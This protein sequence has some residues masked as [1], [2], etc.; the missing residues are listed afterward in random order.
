MS[1][2][3]KLILL[4][5][6]ALLCSCARG[7]T[8]YVTPQYSNDFGVFLGLSTYQYEKL[9][10][11]KNVAIEI[12]EFEPEHLRVV[13]NYNIDIYAYLSVGSLEE[14]KD[15]YFDFKDYELMEYENWPGEY[16]MDVTYTP[17][18]DK[19]VSLA[20]EFKD[21][22]AKGL[23]LDNFDIYYQIE[24]GEWDPSFKEEIYQACKI[25]LSRLSD[26]GMSLVVNSGSTFLERLNEENDPL[27]SKIEWYAQETVFTS[28]INYSGDVF[29]RQTEEEK[30]Y[31]LS[32]IEFMK[33]TANI[34]LIEYATDTEIIEEIQA[35][36]NANGLYFYIANSTS[37]N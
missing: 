19:M 20:N 21:L 11:Y 26:T 32:V 16:W 6:S 25:I 23:F 24:S 1:F 12:E 3:K 18:Q 22:G 35:Y 8:N 30:E 28:I 10:T 37:L 5:S 33:K 27:L 29:G 4:F 36:A 34:L 2:F 7:N 9:L 15:Y 13:K 14:Y 31:Y 17:W